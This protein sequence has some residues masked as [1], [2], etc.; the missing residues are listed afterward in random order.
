M[1]FSEPKSRFPMRISK[2][3]NSPLKLRL[4]LVLIFLGLLSVLGVRAISSNSI[5]SSKWLKLGSEKVSILVTGG[6][7]FIGSHT[8]LELLVRGFDVLVIDSLIN[9]NEESLRRVR[10]LAAGECG[11]TCGTLAFVKLDLL[12]A[13]RLDSTLQSYGPFRSVIH[14][15]ALKSVG[16]SVSRPLDYYANNLQA[17]TN[18]LRACTKHKIENIVF[19]S[20]ATVYGAVA[21]SPMREMA[22]P[23]GQNILNPYGQTKFMAEV[24][25]KDFAQANPKARIACLRYF[26]PV[27]AHASGEIG[28]DP[29]GIPTNLVPYIARV[30]SGRL[31]SLTIYGNDYEGSE[32]GTA[33]RDYIHV[34]DLALGHIAALKWLDSI[35]EDTG[36]FEAVNIGTGNAIS[37]L[38]MVRAYE[39]ASG[40][41]I[42]FEVGPRRVGDAGAVWADATKAKTLFSWEAT[43]T[44]DDMA[45]DSWRWVSK[46]P[47]GY[48]K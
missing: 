17:L 44:L 46:N 42:K 3:T 34:V 14:F 22:T 10:R 18:V 31:P 13:E 38:E 19:S 45:A 7:G 27:G 21:K 48:P 4:A 47:S 8:C 2:S 41:E 40:K 43:H 5:S 37:V 30:A 32:D 20:S 9:S 11:K 28:E 39:K 6:A 33:R 16:E 26:N 23:V 29:L 35:P 15:A 12:D 1:R 25:L 24:I 36:A